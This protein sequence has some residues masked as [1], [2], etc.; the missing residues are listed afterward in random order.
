MV[1]DPQGPGPGVEGGP[2][3]RA[4]TPRGLALVVSPVPVSEWNS[5]PS[6]PPA[7]LVSERS[8]TGGLEEMERR[9]PC[10]QS[11]AALFT[12]A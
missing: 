12:V 9:V 8:R 4:L 5:H 7:G 3:C 2:P 6:P 1:R 10:W 11:A